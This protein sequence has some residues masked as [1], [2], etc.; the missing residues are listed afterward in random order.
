MIE[1]YPPVWLMYSF[2][3]AS[4]RGTYQEQT[5]RIQDKCK[6]VEQESVPPH[7]VVGQRLL[8]ADPFKLLDPPSI[9]ISVEPLEQPFAL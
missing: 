5:K 8:D 9:R 3:I 2:Y 6:P 7:K 1:G 4:I